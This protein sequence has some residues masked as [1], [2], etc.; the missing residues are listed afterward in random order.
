MDSRLSFPV[1]K[2]DLRRPD[3]WTGLLFSYVGNEA[4]LRADHPLRATRALTDETLA[5][6]RQLT[7]LYS[8]IGRP[9]IAPQMLSAGH[10]IASVLLGAL[11]PPADGAQGVRPFTP[12]VRRPRRGRAG[13]TPRPSR[14]SG[15][16][17]LRAI[18][19]E[20]FLAM[21]MARPWEK[22]LLSSDHFSVDG[23]MIQA[24]ASIK[25]V[26]PVGH[27]GP[28]DGEPPSGR[29]SAEANFHGETRTNAAHASTTDPRGFVGARNHSDEIVA[30]ERFDSPNDCWRHNRA[31]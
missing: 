12:L 19:T 15:D 31:I 10:T 14:R 8:G 25:S 7:A 26:T 17:C 29:C 4:R 20:R 24:W 6:E 16:R 18:W 23:A 27:D 2:A 21:L 13:V 11:R 3:E 22:R 9:S 30:R 1:E 5:F 28:D